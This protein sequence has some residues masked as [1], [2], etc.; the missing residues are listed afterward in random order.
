MVYVPYLYIHNLLGFLLFFG[1]IPSHVLSGLEKS[2]RFGKWVSAPP[3]ESTLRL[4][5]RFS[6]PYCISAMILPQV[7]G[8]MLR[9]EKEQA[10]P[11]RCLWLLP[12][13]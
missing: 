1:C 7:P 2:M 13:L 9:A 6:R 8:C 10:Y 11:Y 12:L 4:R 5:I 3:C